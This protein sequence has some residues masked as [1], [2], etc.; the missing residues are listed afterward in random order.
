[1]WKKIKSKLPLPLFVFIA[2]FCFSQTTAMGQDTIIKRNKEKIICKVIEINLNE[3]KYHRLDLPNGPIYVLPKELLNAVVYANGVKED[4]STFEKPKDLPLIGSSDL[5]IQPAN[6]LYFYK[7]HVISELEMLD[8]AW[9]QKDKKINLFVNKTEHERVVK[10][11]FFL[12][13]VTLA[14]VSLINLTGIFDLYATS[15]QISTSGSMNHSYSQ[16]LRN[17]RME[18]FRVSSDLMIGALACSAVS[19]VYKIKERKSARL[20]VSLYNQ[21]LIK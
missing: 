5:S 13:G 18:R 2:V 10:K 11:L 17:R 6:G 21:N 9:A 12:G 20:V 8:I 3:L 1:M 16:T 4:F 14:T 19:V 15:T 7:G